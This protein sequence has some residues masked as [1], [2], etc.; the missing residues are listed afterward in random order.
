MNKKD[1]ITFLADSKPELQSKFGVVKIGLFGS[2]SRGEENE[3]SD[4]DIVVDM[5][6]K[7]YFKLLKLEQF[8]SAKLNK[9]IDIGFINSYR[10]VIKDEIEKDMI[11]V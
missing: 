4:I 5:G 1:I 3:N 9:K 8:L 10:L 6:K 11:Y 2:Y 7:N